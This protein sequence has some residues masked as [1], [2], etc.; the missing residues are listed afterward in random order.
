MRP[1]RSS[2]KFKLLLLGALALL[3]T[4]CNHPYSK[5]YNWL[6]PNWTPD[7]RIVF[8]EWY[9]EFGRKLG[10]IG[11]QYSISRSYLCLINKD[12]TGYTRLT[13]SIG[14]EA[15]STAASKDKL[16]ACV[17]DEKGRYQMLLF[18]YNGNLIKTL[19]QGAYADFS[20]DGKKIVYQKYEGDNPKGIWIMDLESGEERCLVSYEKATFPSW[21][22]TGDKIAYV[23]IGGDIVIIDT[24]G[25]VLYDSLLSFFP[26]Y[27]PDWSLAYP[28]HIAGSTG[29]NIMILNL[30]SM[31]VETLDITGGFANFAW[32]PDGEWFIAYDGSYFVI[33]RDGSYKIYLTPGG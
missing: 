6:A 18:D 21:S 19:G 8:I 31:K 33:R 15:I 26:I 16:I 3:S 24:L 22:S 23:I 11:N 17:T 4:S 12:G 9:L 25:N 13:D 1:K 20:P 14:V 27:Y 2:S 10:G 29:P 32:S 28:N 30:D 5:G 7:G